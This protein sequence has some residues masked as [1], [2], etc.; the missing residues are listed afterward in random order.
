MDKIDKLKLEINH[1]LWFDWNPLGLKEF[2][3]QDEYESY[4]PILLELLISGTEISHI[5]DA[6]FEIETKAM[7]LVGNHQHCKSVAEKI[8]SYWEAI[9]KDL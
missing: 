8:F 7:E 1:I 9:M 4:T 5:A 3:P 2:G 6:L